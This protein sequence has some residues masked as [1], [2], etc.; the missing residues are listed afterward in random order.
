MSLLRLSYKRL[1]FSPPT[2][3]FLILS[4]SLSLSLPLSPPASG[5][6]HCSLLMKEAAMLGAPCGRPREEAEAFHP[7]AHEELRPAR[8]HTPERKA[9]RSSPS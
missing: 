4:P 2:P 1:T 7:A 9:D 8:S 6:S 5:S 3:L